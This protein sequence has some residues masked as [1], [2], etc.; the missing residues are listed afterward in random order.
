MNIYGVGLLAFC[1]IVGQL[2]GEYLG[3][4]IGVKA[5]VGGVG[6]G[7]LLLILLSDFLK[8]KNKF[9]ID[10]ASGIHFWSQ[11]YIPIVI[12]MA[13]SQDVK[14]AFHSGIL[15]IL[16]GILPVFLCFVF[17]RMSKKF[18]KQDANTD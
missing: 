7:M 4:L 16:A 11:M 15:A 1:F 10:E 14:T 18:K 5:N 3:Q 12:A 2:S 17:V 8:R 6:I 9:S 13:A